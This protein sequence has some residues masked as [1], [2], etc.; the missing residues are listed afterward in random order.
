MPGNEEFAELK[1][2]VDRAK[3]AEDRVQQ[4][5]PLVMVMRDDKPRETH[6]LERGNYETPGAVVPPATPSFLPP[7]PA[8][9]KADRLALAKWLVAPEQPLMPRVVLNRIW[10][11]FFGQGLVKTA[12][13]F[14]LQGALPSHPEL[15]DWLAVEFRESGWNVK[16]LVKL[17]VTSRTYQQAAVLTPELLAKD[18]ENALLARGPRFRLDS[19]FI[20]DQALALSGLLVEKQGGFPV[21]PYQPPGIWEDISFGKNR[22][23]QGTG[24]DL[25]RRSLYTFWRRSA[26]PANFFDAP[27]RQVCALK[28]NRTNTP[29]QALT[30]LND[31]TYVEAARVWAQQLT[32]LTDD[33]AKL[34]RLVLTATAR[35]PEPREITSLMKTLTQAREHYAANAA[36]ADKL[37]AT[38]EA[39]CDPALDAREHAAWT[40]VCLLVLNLDETLTQ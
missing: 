24:E 22:Y 27:S 2:A 39:P 33:T 23:F 6:I 19:R 8:G 36:E 34:R 30:T 31:T 3:I 14:G 38:G 35:E 1:H 17:I 10:Q 28:P 9:A 40:T 32:P 4:T 18:P 16:H 20:R 15:L 26:G 21:M 29:L 37:V 12:D 5:I 13:D 7:L 11:M 25:H